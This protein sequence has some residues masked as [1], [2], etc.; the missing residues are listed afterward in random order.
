MS[1]SCGCDVWAEVYS[2]VWRRARKEHT[3]E[4]CQKTIVPG[5]V[6][7][8]VSGKIEG[9][10]YHSKMCEKCQD[11]SDS[12]WAMG[13]CWPKGELHDAWREYIDEVQPPRLHG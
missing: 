3:C 9:W 13:Y 5:E 7:S 10:W 12:M 11:L 1:L 2:Q 4:E 8:S 6:Y